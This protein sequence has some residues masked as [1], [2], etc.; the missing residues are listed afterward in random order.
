MMQTISFRY[1]KDNYFH[2]SKVTA[3]PVQIIPVSRLEDAEV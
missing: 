1:F 3:D 2:R